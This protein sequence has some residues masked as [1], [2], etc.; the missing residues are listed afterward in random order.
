MQKS[1][2]LVDDEEGIRKVL[3]NGCGMNRK[4]KNNIFI[5]FF[6]TKGSEGTGIGVMITKK[7]VDEHD[8]EIY[9]ESKEGSGSAF[10]IRIPARPKGK[11]H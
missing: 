2:L 6:S 1:I 8:G 7:I 9:V 3:D 10:L 11:K 5:G 4:I